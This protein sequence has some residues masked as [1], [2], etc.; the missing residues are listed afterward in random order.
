MGALLNLFLRNG[1]KSRRTWW[2]ALLGLFPVGVA[3]FLWLVRPL[4]EQREPPLWGLFPPLGL[5]LFLNLLLPLMTI[6]VGTA[7][8]TDEVE[9]RTLGYLLTRPVPRGRIVLAK[10]AA[11]F[12]TL[13]AVLA[14]SLLA[15]YTVLVLGEGVPAWGRNL[16]LLL[17]AEGVLLLGLAAYLALFSLLGGLFKRAVWVG[18]LFAFGW[19]RLVAML[20]G[21]IKLATVIHYLHRLYPITEEGR[22]GDIRSLVFGAPA[23]PRELSEWTALMVLLAL[24]ALFTLLA[25]RLLSW[26]EYR[27]EQGE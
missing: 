11:G 9:E 19:E 18:L 4:I 7:V 16:G 1:L 14:L 22:G 21:N 5:M 3:I 23:P 13:G 10:L 15:T 12:V 8:I 24:T 27:L 6:F 2:M 17:R 20:P 25:A 26:K